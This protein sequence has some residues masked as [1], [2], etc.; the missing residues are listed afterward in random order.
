MNELTAEKTYKSIKEYIKYHFIINQDKR[1]KILP[2][3]RFEFLS[4]SL[5]DHCS[6]QWAH[7]WAHEAG[8]LVF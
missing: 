5:Q 1:E 4:P 6:N 2:L 7:Q 8:T 3:E